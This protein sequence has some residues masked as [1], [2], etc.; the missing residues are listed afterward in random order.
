[1]I[2]LQY[3]RPGRVLHT[4]SATRE[5]SSAH[6]IV[7]IHQLD[8][9]TLHIAF[10]SSSRVQLHMRA[11]TLSADASSLVSEAK[12]GTR[13]STPRR[14]PEL[15]GSTHH[16]LHMCTTHHVL[17]MHTLPQY[18]TSHASY[19][20]VEAQYWTCWVWI[21]SLSTGHARLAYASIVPDIA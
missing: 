19:A 4:S 17:H 3:P 13:S 2:E 11:P 8:L 21:P 6:C 12:T 18:R 1:M 15:R 9:H 10:A 7:C 14:I 5:L 20:Y 16:I